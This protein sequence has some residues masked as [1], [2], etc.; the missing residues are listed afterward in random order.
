MFVNKQKGRI[1]IF[2]A[3]GN[4]ETF[5]TLRDAAAMLA[6]RGY[7]V[8]IFTKND[9]N[10][11][12]V[13]INNQL[14]SVINEPRIFTDGPA[15]HLRK[16]GRLYGWVHAY[17]IRPPWLKFVFKPKIRRNHTKLP[18]TC[19]IGMDSQGLVDGGPFAELLGVPLVYWSLELLLTENISTHWKDRWKI[20]LKNKEKTFSQ[21]AEFTIIQDNLR[22]QAL[23]EENSLDAKRI[24]IVPNAPSGKAQHIPNNYLRDRLNIPQDSKIVLCA[25]AIAWGTMSSEIIEAAADWPDGYVLVIQS[26]QKYQK[27]NQQ[28]RNMALQKAKPP[29]VYVLQEPVSSNQ[30]KILVQSADV[31]LALY[32]DKPPGSLSKPDKNLVLMGMA[33]GKLS[34]Y[35][36]AG[37]PVIVNQVFGPRELINSYKCG[38]C[39][40]S[41]DE[42]STALK[43]ICEQYDY[44]S[45]NACRCFNETLEF[46][47]Y[48]SAV[49][50][51]LEGIK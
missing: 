15:K 12:P 17:M 14:I 36:Q 27:S 32:Q 11:P 49:I 29:K 41:P 37:L 21:K 4:L 10:Y 20:N 18:Y 23:V 8:E 48:F 25:G 24:V 47:K 50:D 22:A 28:Y 39:V 19:I 26:R 51:R 42:I 6:E 31:G 45:A 35:L 16:G 44:F 2:Y 40:S 3:L 9:S 13:V 5:P 34:D 46:E 38:I 33:S 7:Q 30:Y 1:A 43:E